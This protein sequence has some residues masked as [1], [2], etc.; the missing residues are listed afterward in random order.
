MLQAGVLKLA[1]AHLGGKKQEC[2]PTAH[3]QDLMELPNDMWH[4]L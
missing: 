1:N 3:K 4:I 2:I